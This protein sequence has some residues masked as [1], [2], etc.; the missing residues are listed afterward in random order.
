MRSPV[1][2]ITPQLREITPQLRVWS[3]EQRTFESKRAFGHPEVVVLIWTDTTT[4]TSPD[5]P[6]ALPPWHQPCLKW[7]RY[8]QGSRLLHVCV[9]PIQVV[10]RMVPQKLIYAGNCGHPA[11][12]KTLQ[13]DN[14]HSSLTL[15]WFRHL[16]VP[17][18]ILLGIWSSSCPTATAYRRLS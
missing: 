9:A 14:S 13:C 18:A 8:C 15:Q 6:F 5:I 4:C 17:K 16:V 7:G 10:V 11:S 12:A 2:E 3:A 1:R